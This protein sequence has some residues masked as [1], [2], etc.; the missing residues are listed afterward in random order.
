MQTVYLLSVGFAASTWWHKIEDMVGLRL[1][2]GFLS[3]EF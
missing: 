2:A 1:R 3:E